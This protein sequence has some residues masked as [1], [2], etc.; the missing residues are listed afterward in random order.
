MWA[1]LS[2]ISFVLDCHV[3]LT[4]GKEKNYK[5]DEAVE[6]ASHKLFRKEY[7]QGK[8]L[9]LLLVFEI[10]CNPLFLLTSVI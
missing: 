5:R 3:E 9:V 4:F 6:E 8:E 2:H 1:N 7:T 10:F